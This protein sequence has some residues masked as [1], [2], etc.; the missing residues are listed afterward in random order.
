MGYLTHSLI[1]LEIFPQPIYILKCPIQGD[2][3]LT[4][5]SGILFPQRVYMG[6]LRYVGIEQK[7]KLN[8]SNM[9]KKREGDLGIGWADMRFVDGVWRLGASALARTLADGQVCAGVVL[10]PTLIDRGRNALLG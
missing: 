8:T 9:R 10:L 2:L 4:S 3:S 5:Q 6:L 7:K 1:L